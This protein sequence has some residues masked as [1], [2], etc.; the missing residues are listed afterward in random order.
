V[1]NYMDNIKAI[2]TVIE[3]MLKYIRGHLFLEWGALRGIWK[4]TNQ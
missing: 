3:E 1:K 4:E 2:Q